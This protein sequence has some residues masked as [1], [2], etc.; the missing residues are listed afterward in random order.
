[1]MH[2]LFLSEVA[3]IAAVMKPLWLALTLALVLVAATPAPVQAAL[4]LTRM[5]QAQIA[6]N[7]QS[8]A[9]R[10]QALREALTYTLLKVSG[11]EQVLSHDLVQSALQNVSKFV[12]QYGYRQAPAVTQ[13]K[14]NSS[15]L[16][17]D[18][19]SPAP[20]QELQ[21][22]VQFDQP[23]IDRLLQEAGSGVWSNLRPELL[24]WTVYEDLNLRR[25]LLGSGDNH[26][27]SEFMQQL[28]T[29]ANARGLPIKLP[30]LD[31]NDSMSLS[32][33]DVW[34]R[35]EDTL[36]FASSR[37]SPDGVITARV[38]QAEPTPSDAAIEGAAESAPQWVLDW[39]LQLGELR[40]RGE[41]SSSE[42][43]QLA[44]LFIS[45]VTAQLAQRYRISSHAGSTQQWQLQVQNVT[46]LTQA[47][48][49]EQ[50]LL[51]LP[52]VANVQIEAYGEH[53]A[54]FNLLLQTNP[55][56]ILQAID[57]S[58]Q[59]RPVS[60]PGHETEPAQ[61]N[62]RERFLAPQTPEQP[63][64]TPPMPVYRWVGSE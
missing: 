40:W 57:L 43:V 48:A 22:W 59:M 46:S 50:F 58:K 41:V 39:V 20:V 47:I 27:A 10:N 9:Q 6:V 25:R 2:L 62:Y 42:Q 29:H 36:A 14:S 45:D 30:L 56:Q 37:Y 15:N 53:T 18:D 64:K 21:L 26:E 24:I 35:F 61:P 3:M 32:V 16:S 31:L 60:V 19:T 63:P 17:N 34:A 8:V 54:Q 52:S 49:A 4:E 28:V 7:D 5:Y 13:P 33:L 51:A 1:M 12:V 38:Y 23:Q 55:G 44:Q 11:D